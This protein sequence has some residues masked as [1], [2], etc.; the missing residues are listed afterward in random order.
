MD[1]IVDWKINKISL[2]QQ[3]NVLRNIAQKENNNEMI[4]Q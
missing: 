1:N 3:W 4:A 2:S